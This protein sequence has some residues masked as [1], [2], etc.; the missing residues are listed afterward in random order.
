MLVKKGQLLFEVHSYVLEEK[1]KYF[2]EKVVELDLL[3][4]DLKRLTTNQFIE[5]H[6]VPGSLKPTTTLYEQSL[7]D[8]TQK[9]S[10]RVTRFQKIR[11]DYRRNKILYD[12]GVIAKSEFE[13]YQFE[14]DKAKSDLELLK[15]SQLSAWQLELHKYEDER[16]EFQ[17]QLSQVLREKE[18][19]NI[20]APIKG[21]IQGLT[22][23]YPGSQIFP[24]QDLAQISPDTTLVAELYVNP[25]DIGLIREGMKVRMQISAFN[26]NQWGLLEGNVKE[27]S[28]DV[29]LSNQEP[30]FNVRCTLLQEHLSLKNG[31]QGKLKKG[32][33]LQARCVVAKRS[34]WQLL[35]D[36]VDDW[37]N[38]GVH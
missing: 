21:T 25:K 35:Y 7:S 32:M 13:N 31:Y 19:L 8:Y 24:N 22:G 11:Q 28:N 33:M 5:N 16:A 3:L 4:D 26:Y 15:Q 1:E 27:I 17:N 20:I 12:G 10:D 37:I 2:K 30:F 38:P 29:Q 23:I 9:L 6:K 34:I 18:S 36:K 14:L